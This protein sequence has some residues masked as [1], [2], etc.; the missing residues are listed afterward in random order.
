MSHLSDPRVPSLE[1]AVD[2]TIVVVSSE[3]D[4]PAPSGGVITLGDGIV[5][6]ISGTVT[7]S[8]DVRIVTGLNTVLMGHARDRDSLVG[9]IAS[10]LVSV[11]TTRNSLKI[12][13]LT[14][15]QNNAGGTVLDTVDATL[16]RLTI[17]DA[18]LSAAGG[19]AVGSIG[20]NSI[21]F[22]RTS[23]S[24]F[25]SGLTFTGTGNNT[26]VLDGAG[27]FQA[28][29]TGGVACLDLGS[30][31]W[32]VIRLDNMTVSAASSGF[33]L[34]GLTSNGNFASAAGRGTVRNVR[35]IGDGTPLENV[36]QD[37]LQWTFSQVSGIS[38]TVALG[39]YRMADNASETTITTVDTYTI[40]AGTTTADD[41]RR[42][43]HTG[44]NQL[45][46]RGVDTLIAQ[47]FVTLSAFKSGG[48]TA[49][50]FAIFINGSQVGAQISR[51]L[52]TVTGSLALIATAELS[53]DDVIDVRAQNLDGTDNLTVETLSVVVHGNL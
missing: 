17:Q 38:E 42:F 29:G 53:T 16:N 23:F 31:T 10:S 3:S 28:D 12:T 8:N 40:I 15:V 4:F 47:L 2:P 44:N 50:E 20:A 18:L 22:R 19:G 5:Y 35:F 46:Y 49:F 6:I 7:L 32:N 11:P 25:A 51:E 37:D 41:E 21:S 39:S 43:E 45:T 24:G 36:T 48:A 52:N 13:N 1:A 34:S 30:S 33:G 26:L 14:L 9:S 27:V